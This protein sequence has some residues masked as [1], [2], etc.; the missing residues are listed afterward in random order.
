MNKDTARDY[1]PL[2]QALADGKVIQFKC[3]GG[4]EDIGLPSFSGDPS[5]WRI[6]P[7]PREIWVNHYANPLRL[8]QVCDSQDE[9]NQRANPEHLLCQRRY[10]EVIE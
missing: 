7:E 10:R 6:K 9:A 1:L 3:A 8:D 5:D 2:V 4:W